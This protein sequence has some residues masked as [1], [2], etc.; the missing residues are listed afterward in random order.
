MTHIPNLQATLPAGAYVRCLNATGVEIWVLA[1]ALAVSVPSKTIV[2]WN[3]TVANIPAGWGEYTAARGRV[4]VGMPSGGTLAGT[5]GSALTNLQDL[6]H[7]HTGPSHTHTGPSHTHAMKNHT[8]TGPSHKH[9]LPFAMGSAAARIR[10]N[11]TTPVFGTGNNITPNRESPTGF[12][13][14][15]ASP[16]VL[17]NFGGT[18]A[19]GAPSDNTSDT[20]G[21]GD[22]GAGG[23]GATGTAA[24]S[25]VIPYIQQ[26]AMVKS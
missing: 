7:T 2:F 22:T 16:A 25:N 10:M 5:V 3:D 21:T 6:T 19:T 15:T 14:T 13:D 4:I 20:G 23:T 26:V 8:H 12:N 18:G 17:S 11:D 1:T 24:T 9:E